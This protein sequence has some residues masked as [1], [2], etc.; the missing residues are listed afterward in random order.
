MKQ[1]SLYDNLLLLE[2]IHYKLCMLSLMTGEL[3]KY[4]LQ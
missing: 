2:N 3:S 4:I 1:I